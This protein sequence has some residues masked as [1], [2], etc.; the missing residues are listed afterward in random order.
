V[1]ACEI[2][3]YLLGLVQL[4]YAKI[5]ITAEFVDPGTSVSVLIHSVVLL[6]LSEHFIHLGSV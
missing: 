5:I 1:Y 2:H 6:V 4:G 3:I